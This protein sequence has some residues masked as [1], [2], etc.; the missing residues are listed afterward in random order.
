MDGTV[1]KWILRLLGVCVAF[2]LVLGW[3][4][5]ETRQEL[6]VA[7]QV[8]SAPGAILRTRIRISDAI[9]HTVETPR[10]INSSGLPE[11]DKEHAAEHARRIEVAL[12]ELKNTG[13]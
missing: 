9:E 2:L 7:M 3:I 1:G 8:Q 4:L 12:R 10:S 11:T 13:G 6:N 5:V